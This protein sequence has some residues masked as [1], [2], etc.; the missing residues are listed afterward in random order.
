MPRAKPTPWTPDT[1]GHEVPLPSSDFARRVLGALGHAPAVAQA[2]P[3]NGPPAVWVP[4]AYRAAER[5]PVPAAV[6]R[7]LV[8]VGL[9]P[10]LQRDAGA[11]PSGGAQ[12][13][14]LR[15]VAARAR[16]LRAAVQGLDHR[17]LKRLPPDARP[18]SAFEDNLQR[19]IAAAATAAN[20]AA[21]AA[22]REKWPG[23]RA[24]LRQ[25]LGMWRR[26]AEAGHRGSARAR[27]TY[28]RTL[29][30]EAGVPLP[31]EDRVLDRLLR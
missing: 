18:T 17:S 24:W 3:W 9:W 31:S 23:R 15:A 20:D 27:R 22:P 5:G 28:L 2:P 4:A 29:A 7:A 30:D 13:A 16:A 1:G 6:A 14:A 8:V 26:D 19:L 25:A 21:G 10:M 11:A 12:A